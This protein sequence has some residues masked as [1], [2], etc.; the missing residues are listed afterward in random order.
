M[1]EIGLLAR[2][3]PEIEDVGA[4]KE[5][6]NLASGNSW[7]G[8]NGEEKEHPGGT[9]AVKPELS[10]KDKKAIALLVV[11]C[12]YAPFFSCWVLCS[13]RAVASPVRC[14]SHV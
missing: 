11:L 3:R 2:S 6:A 5:G 14:I 13:L 1:E 7:N 4:G 10:Q 9:A 8:A 12:E